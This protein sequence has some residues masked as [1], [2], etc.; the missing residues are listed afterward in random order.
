MAQDTR[1]QKTLKKFFYTD[2]GVYNSIND[3]INNE[4]FGSYRAFVQ[5]VGT[6]R[7]MHYM[8][9]FAKYLES[10]SYTDDLDI[11]EKAPFLIR[12]EGSLNKDI[13]D[14]IVYQLVHPLGW[15]YSY[16]TIISVILKDYYGITTFVTLEKL[17]LYNSKEFKYVVFTDKTYEE[18]V[19]NFLTRI[20]PKTNKKFT[21]DEFSSQ[22]TVYTDKHI[23][24]YSHWTDENGYQQKL[25]TFKDETVLYYDGSQQKIYYTT[26]YDYLGGC[27]NPINIYSS[28]YGI[29][30]I[31]GSD[32]EFEYFDEINGYLKE[33]TVTRYL[34]EPYRGV[35]D[36]LIKIEDDDEMF[37]LYPH[38]LLKYSLWGDFDVFGFET[39]YLDFKTFNEA[40][41]VPSNY[42]EDQGW[43]ITDEYTDMVFYQ[44]I[45]E[46]RSLASEAGNTL[47]FI[48][49]LSFTESQ[50]GNVYL[51]DSKFEQDTLEYN[52]E[53]SKTID[54]V[55]YHGKWLKIKYNHTN[56]WTDVFGF[57]TVFSDYKTFNEANF[58]P[59]TISTSQIWHASD[60][61]N[62][63]KKVWIDSL[64]YEYVTFQKGAFGFE[65]SE[66]DWCTFNEGYLASNKSSVA[67]KY[68]T[69]YTFAIIKGH[70]AENIST[71]RDDLPEKFVHAL[72]E[73]RKYQNE[74]FGFD[75]RKEATEYN[76]FENFNN[77]VFY[78]EISDAIIYPLATESLET[79]DNSVLV[80]IS[81]GT[82][83]TFSTLA[84]VNE[85]TKTFETGKINITD[86]KSGYYE[87]SA[88]H[89]NLEDNSNYTAVR[90]N[91]FK[92][93]TNI[94]KMPEYGNDMERGL[95]RNVYYNDVSENLYIYQDLLINI[96]DDA[97]FSDTLKWQPK[98]FVT[99]EEDGNL[100][101]KYRVD[102][103]IGELFNIDNVEYAEPDKWT[104]DYINTVKPLTF[105]PYVF[106]KTGL[107]IEGNDYNLF[108]D[109]YY[110]ETRFVNLGY[111][112]ERS[113]TTDNYRV[114]QS[115]NV[116]D[117][118]T[119]VTTGGNG[120][121]IVTD[122]MQY[123]YTNDDQYI[124]TTDI[125]EFSEDGERVVN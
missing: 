32:V 9:T 80:K 72:P 33:F 20:N 85:D 14:K 12:Y 88:L 104:A 47:G 22:V 117:E 100:V 76:D 93:T 45:D 55:D 115:Y 39:T 125:E 60:T 38:K 102:T 56:T 10:G 109:D 36:T 111:R 53:Y 103:K 59:S 23:E 62:V 46:G 3:I 7:A 54:T 71:S 8:Y 114:D 6:K 42:E 105:K 119:I 87:L 106:N 11:S 25:Y 18:V 94:V 17:E 63:V 116:S 96:P 99:I 75:V 64:E 24:D 41:F 16:T 97:D 74:T 52:D 57:E 89:G 1:I 2:A 40:G 44:G 43:Y 13:F 66:G 81:D 35:G 31:L 118:M 78:N 49:D 58:T 69:T 108:A 83:R 67:N 121:Y 95:R 50:K 123:L 92:L 112:K 122:D 30:A 29:D 65:T 61:L 107:I 5:M 90:G 34:E 70:Y 4:F 113:E 82:G 86:F 21:L 15:A 84:S 37:C 19:E 73:K 110:Y 77:G 120:G 98:R 68:A 79:S 124:T 91:Y 26:Y 27:T 48:K 101:Q 51:T 28:D